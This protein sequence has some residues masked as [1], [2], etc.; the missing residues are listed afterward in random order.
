MKRSPEKNKIVH[1]LFANK[2]TVEFIN[3][4]EKNFS[5]YDITIVVRGNISELE[6]IK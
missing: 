4:L 1:L 3:F 5:Q 2:F 6:K